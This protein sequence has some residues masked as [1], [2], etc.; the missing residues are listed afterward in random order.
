MK[1]FIMVSPY[2]PPDK[3]QSGIY[4]AVDN[5]KLQ[6]DK[7]TAFPVIPLI[8]GYAEP[9]EEIEVIA[10]VCRYAN[11][12]DNLK[13]FKDELEDLCKEMHLNCHVEPLNID[14]S[15]DLDTLLDLFGQLIECTS[16]DDTLYACISYGTKP[17]PLVLTMALQFGHRIHSNVC[18]GCVAYGIKDFLSNEMHIYDITSLLYMDEIVR[19]MADQ[20]VS[21]PVDKIKALLK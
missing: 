7:P 14:Y 9:G 4:K 19:I 12:T 17:M 13:R 2:Q 8:H 5:D 1:K 3:V 10:V 18:F 16:D 15:N 11:A 20:K 21:D 6:Y